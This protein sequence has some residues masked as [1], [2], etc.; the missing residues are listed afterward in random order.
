MNKSTAITLICAF[1]LIGFLSAGISKFEGK[2]DV[3][4]MIFVGFFSALTSFFLQFTFS[5]GQI[6]G[7]G[8]PFLEKKFRDNPKSLFPWLS[9]P[10][11]LCPY[12]QNIWICIIAFAI[13]NIHIGTTFWLLIPATAIAHFS[14]TLLDK[15]FWQD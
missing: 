14:L 7:K 12:C 10:L 6:F 4:E 5:P 9:E 13:M 3:L 8:I 1:F 15:A 2:Q 11:G